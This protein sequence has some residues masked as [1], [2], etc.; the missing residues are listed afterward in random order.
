MELNHAGSK[1]SCGCDAH[2]VSSEIC[3]VRAWLKL[4]ETSQMGMGI[5]Q[6]CSFRYF[7]Q[8]S[9]FS[10]HT[11]THAHPISLLQLNMSSFNTKAIHH[12]SDHNG[13]ADE[14]GD[15]HENNVLI[16]QWFRYLFR[17]LQTEEETR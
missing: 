3:V 1:G 11:T 17:H 8:S 5:P 12:D 4:I 14:R 7:I 10:Y 6:S 13:N 16:R 9:S 15:N 2:V